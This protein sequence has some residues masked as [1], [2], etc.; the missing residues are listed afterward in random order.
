[1]YKKIKHQTQ[2]A[3]RQTHNQ[4]LNSIF[5]S[6]SSNK[7]LFTYVKNRK[8][9]NVGIPDLKSEKGLPVR[10]PLKKAELIHKQFDSV[11]SDPSPP[12][13]ATLDN[14]NKVPTI[15]AIEVTSPGIRKLL[16]KI[17][18][19]KAIGPDNIPNH[20]LKLCSAPMADVLATLYQ[21][22][23][24]QG[25]VPPDWKSANI[26][27]LYKKGDK[28]NPG[29]YRPISLTSPTCKILEH[30][31][32]S[33]IM[34]HL[35]NHSILDDAQHGFRKN[36]S[37]VSQLI[38]TLNDFANSLKAQKQTDAILLDFSKAFDK[39]D[40]L[41]LLSKLENY[42][43][44]GP[45]LE[46]TSSFLIGR[47]QRVVVDGQASP[48]SN[49]LSGVPQGTVLGPL[50][51]L[52]YINDISKGLSKGTSIRL[53]AD[54]SLLYR[55]INSPK[56]CEILQRDLDRLQLWEKTWKME[57]H[58]EKCNLL[59]ITN[60]LKPFDHTYKIHNTPLSKTDSAKYLGVVIDSKLTWKPHYNHLIKSCKSTL[61]FIK[62]NIPHKAPRFIKSKCYL[63]LV[64]PK[65]EYASPVWD[66]Y[67]SIYK[68]NIEKIQ[69]SAARYVTNNYTMESGNSLA[70]LQTLGWKTLEERRIDNKLGLFKK[71]LLGK[72]DIPTDHLTVK[73][74]Q[75]RRGGGGPVY[76]REFSK[77]DAHRN[78]FYPSTTR[79]Y[80]NLPLELR[81]CSDINEFARR[82]S[83]IN[84][85]ELRD[86]LTHID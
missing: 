11:F 82:L 47:K 31:V 61:S 9:E 18:P 41:G 35:E 34:T 3:C 8:Q 65:A 84:L 1:M 59:Q 80:N 32:Y 20:F 77:I 86:S 5:S 42:G 29:N 6:D 23:L 56:D 79:L 71:G 72:L 60:K 33:N 81:L 50:F 26:V 16:E 52:V 66:P 39:V 46:W 54:D 76:M 64:R 55:T 22:S 83:K 62:R 10:D 4:Y 38:T 74:R 63:T 14:S 58:P 37:C 12:I 53:F 51:F 25:V 67:Q 24:N 45:L 73:T 85:V 69:K 78:S 27:P 68:N 44:R 2:T 15:P 30:V 40:H 43:I 57:F 7:K 36:R 48:D 75:T 17:D 28:S 70:N 19:H 13:Q 49:V 21:A